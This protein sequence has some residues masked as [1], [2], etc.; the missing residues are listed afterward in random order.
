M[1]VPNY[2][3]QFYEALAQIGARYQLNIENVQKLIDQTMPSKRHPRSAFDFKSYHNLEEI[4]D[5]MDYLAK[6]YPNKVKVVV[7]G[8][9]YEGRQIKGIKVSFKENNP[10]IFIEGGNHAREWISPATVMYILH[11]LLTSNN[12]DVRNLSE[13]HDWYIF[14]VFNPDGYV[15]TH[16]MVYLI[17]Q[18]RFAC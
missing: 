12:S 3:P 18:H 6:Q 11:Q 16:N 10:G 9:T 7:G 13:S 17:F 14:P 5:N 1:V 15:Y 4:Y 2:L 8:T